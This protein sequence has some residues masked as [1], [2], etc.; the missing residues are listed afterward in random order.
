[1]LCNAVVIRRSVRSRGNAL[2]GCALVLGAALAGSALVHARLD[3]VIDIRAHEITNREAF[4]AGHRHYSQLTTIVWLASL[5]YM[6]ITVSAWR[7]VD[8]QGADKNDS[9]LAAHGR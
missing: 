7:H 5:A 6:A 4:T 2:L 1:M 9:V 8:R 3:S